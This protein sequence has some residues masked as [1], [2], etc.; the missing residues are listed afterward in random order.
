M[1]PSA[2]G[3]EYKEAFLSHLF[4]HLVK[5][6]W[7]VPAE[8]ALPWNLRWTCLADESRKVRAGPPAVVLTYLGC[9]RARQDHQRPSISPAVMSPA[10]L[11]ALNV[12]ARQKIHRF[13]VAFG[14]APAGHDIR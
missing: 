2:S 13:F 10:P 8:G 1:S 12:V 7:R 3:Y 5:Y 14:Y 4:I 11:K 9:I 6:Y